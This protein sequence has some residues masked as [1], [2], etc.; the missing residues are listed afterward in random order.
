MLLSIVLLIIG[1]VLLSKGADFF[2]DGASN[3]ALK[4]KI[5][6]IIVGLTVVAMGTSAPEAFVSIN[7]ALK[8]VNG[9]AIGNIIGSNIANIFLILGVTAAICALPIKNNTIKYEIP[10]VGFITVILLV[11]GHFFGAVDRIGALVLL[12]LFGLFFI[13]LFKASKN[14]NEFD[15]E[16][17]QIGIIK[18][19]LYI[20]GGLIALVYGS[21]MTVNSA[22]DIAHR[23]NVSD[24]I[25]G[26]TV[27]AFG[28]SLPEL[29]TCIVAAY[30]K[31]T[32]L[33][34]GNIIGSNIF[35]ILFVLG[36]TGMIQPVEFSKAFYF[37]SIVAIF[38]VVLLFIYT[39]K[40]KILKRWQGISFLIL[41]FAYL[42][43]LIVK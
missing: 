21:D 6:Q 10:F 31:Q 41:Y 14:N 5:P 36:I 22:V 30:K 28:T 7:S 2:I 17:K 42:T 38:A 37:D 19:L 9:V 43:V 20:T 32:D 24:R 27:I 23:L 40:S 33:A 4:F 13:Y 15:V 25:I 1:L 11:T 39:F 12:V 16:E 18:I 8:G 26:L 29:I 35:N 34:V 3:L